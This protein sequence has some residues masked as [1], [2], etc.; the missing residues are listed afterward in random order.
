MMLIKT[1][2]GNSGNDNY[3]E[4]DSV[5]DEVQKGTESYNE[6]AS[7]VSVSFRQIHHPDHTIN[8]LPELSIGKTKFPHEV[9][10]K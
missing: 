2:E 4:I 5:A 8:R 10:R 6:D 7:T 1:L 3:V 9:D